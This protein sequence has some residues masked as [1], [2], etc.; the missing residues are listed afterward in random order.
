[1]KFHFWLAISFSTLFMASFVSSQ[2]IESFTYNFKS[3]TDGGKTQQLVLKLKLIPDRC[4]FFFNIDDAVPKSDTLYFNDLNESNIEF[5]LKKI[6]FD[7]VIRN[8]ILEDLKSELSSTQKSIGISVSSALDKTYSFDVTN[9]I[10]KAKVDTTKQDST[11]VK[12]TTKPK[13][14]KKSKVVKK[15]P[16]TVIKDTTK[17]SDA[18]QPKDTTVLILGYKK[19]KPVEIKDSTNSIEISKALDNLNMPSEILHD[20]ADNLSIKLNAEAVK[21]EATQALIRKTGDI[22]IKNR[23]FRIYTGDYLQKGFIRASQKLN[24]IFYDT[25]FTVL[26]VKM[27]FSEGGIKDVI[28]NAKRND[29]I[30][31]FKNF[32]RIPLSTLDDIWSFN[33]GNI[34][35]TTLT[36]NYSDTIYAKLSDIIFYD[37]HLL[38][39]DNYVPVDTT[40][41]IVLDPKHPDEEEAFITLYKRNFIDDF[42]I[43]LYTDA[44]A[45]AKN[46][47]NGLVETELRYNFILNS[48]EA[49]RTFA[50]AGVGI[51]AGAAFFGCIADEFYREHVTF[52]Y[53]A[54]AS[55]IGTFTKGLA[56]AIVPVALAFV[57][58]TI[59]LGKVQPYLSINKLEDR[60]GLVPA[61]VTDST[62]KILHNEFKTIDLLRYSKLDIGINL[63][64][65]E[66]R[67]RYSNFYLKTR[68]N[69]GILQTPFDSLAISPKNP[70]TKVSQ[71]LISWYLMPEFIFRPFSTPNIDFLISYGMRA[72]MPLNTKISDSSIQFKTLNLGSI[73]H[74]F[75]FDF[76]LYPDVKNRDSWYFARAILD[77]NG[78]DKIFRLQLGFS[79]TLDKILPTRTP[80]PQPAKNTATNTTK[81]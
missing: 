11:K 19:L 55:G 52:S 81:Q 71:D 48:I 68:M 10:V 47:T 9:S 76:N 70:Q 61:L 50:T 45:F 40:I 80:P 4:I 25:N 22:M 65:F 7:S 34:E 29:S 63:N 24:E 74:R 17:S 75:Q 79:S 2:T 33:S 77:F 21:Y 13:K 59:G 54:L 42:D 30:F 38:L 35:Y 73:I 27:E 23:T 69:F 26:N 60:G 14:V 51:I 28:V 16:T 62:S 32:H 31:Q 12:D 78:D 37:P 18:I 56:V 46:S 1:M 58:P 64:I 41:E 67:I 43:R 15:P 57:T 3:L 6:Q 36:L 8:F 5:I 49:N 53:P 66:S 44:S 20:I 72:L 39:N